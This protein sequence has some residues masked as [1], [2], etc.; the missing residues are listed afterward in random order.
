MRYF[1]RN[2][3]RYTVTVEYVHVYGTYLTEVWTGLERIVHHEFETAKEC[4]DLAGEFVDHHIS[5]RY[6][7]A[8]QHDAASPPPVKPKS[9]AYTEDCRRKVEKLY[10]GKRLGVTKAARTD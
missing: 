7:W 10:G 4:L 6:L 1:L 8:L 2:D 9:A 5:S 3:A